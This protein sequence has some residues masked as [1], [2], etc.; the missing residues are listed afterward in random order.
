MGLTLGSGSPEAMGRL[1]VAF[2]VL[3]LLV[4]GCQRTSSPA[5][6]EPSP[7]DSGPSLVVNLAIHPNPAT[8]DA[9][10][11]GSLRI[12]GRCLFL[13][14]AEG[15][16]LGVAWPAGT[17]WNAFNGTLDVKGSEVPLD[18][19]VAVGGGSADITPSN[20][21]EIPWIVA[22]LQECLGDSFVFAGTVGPS[23]AT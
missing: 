10:V 6:S 1:V 11:I 23:P 20:L 19:P 16:R 3:G 5:P 18:T 12:E 2:M 13:I 14:T 22:P 17:R 15:I 7:S 4:V 21:H 9:L 8:N